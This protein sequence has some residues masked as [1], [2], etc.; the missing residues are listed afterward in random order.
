MPQ[1]WGEGGPVLSRH[2]ASLPCQCMAGAFAACIPVTAFPNHLMLQVS[3]VSLSTGTGS[4]TKLA[5][6]WIPAEEVIQR[7]N[8]RKKKNNRGMHNP[9]VQ[10]YLLLILQDP[11]Q[12][13]LLGAFLAP[14]PCSSPPT[15]LCP[16]PLPLPSL[17]FPLSFLLENLETVKGIES[18]DMGGTAG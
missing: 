18:W 15:S 10:L 14:S 5:P 12:Q 4:G 6:P 1:W 13:H 3:F 16:F 8:G 9:I 7:M 11:D 2:M 17:T